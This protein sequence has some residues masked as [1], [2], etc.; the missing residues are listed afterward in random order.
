MSSARNVSGG[1]DAHSIDNALLGLFQ[2][3]VDR[4]FAP[5]DPDGVE[6][7]RPELN[8][9]F[10]LMLW[11]SCVWKN[12]PTPGMRM[13]GLRYGSLSRRQLWLLCLLSVVAPYGHERLR[14]LVASRG[15]AAFPEG[16]AEH[17]ASCLL[18]AASNTAKYAHLLNLIAFFAGARHYPTVAER[19]TRAPLRPPAPEPPEVRARPSSATTLG[20][21]LSGGNPAQINF[22][23]MMRQL[24]WDQLVR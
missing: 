18:S 2:A 9:T 20:G 17:T 24:T 16:S 5:L 13:L 12:H 11:W 21:E 8:L 15:W 19:L 23:F 4:F 7:Y 3:H 22:Q 6:L 14:R 10:R 1:L